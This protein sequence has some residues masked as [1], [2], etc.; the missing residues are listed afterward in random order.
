MIRL[1]FL[2][3]VFWGWSVFF[4]Q[5]IHFGVNF[6]SFNWNKSENL[7]GLFNCAH[8]NHKLI[9]KASFKEHMK[10]VSVHAWL[11]AGFNLESLPGEPEA[12]SAMQC[13]CKLAGNI[14][15]QTANSFPHL[16]EQEA[17]CFIT[18]CWTEQGRI[19]NPLVDGWPTFDFRQFIAQKGGEKKR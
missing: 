1:A 5:I 7:E 8:C 2:S 17:N 12:G 11:L 14:S 13:K 6:D 4:S 3:F 9:A 10:F 19:I 16:F 18:N 15:Q